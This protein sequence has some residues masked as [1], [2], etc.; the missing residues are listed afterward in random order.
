MK[1]ISQVTDVER[2]RAKL[3]ANGEDDAYVLRF[4]RSVLSPLAEPMVEAGANI[5]G[6]AK[7]ERARTHTL[8]LLK[9]TLV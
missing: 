3:P 5:G 1:S 7:V 9:M 4:G 2:L 6:D 8:A